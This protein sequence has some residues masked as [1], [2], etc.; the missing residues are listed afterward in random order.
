MTYKINFVSVFCFL[1]III[2]LISPS[3][4]VFGAKSGLMLWF[5]NIVPTLF[6]FLIIITLLN[7]LNGFLILEKPL[8]VLARLLHIP[9]YYTFAIITGFLCGYPMGALLSTNYYKENILSKNECE[10]LCICSNFISPMFLSGYALSMQ[11][12][13]SKKV[14]LL[15]SIY[16]P[17]IALFP[18]HKKVCKIN[19]KT[20]LPNN[21]N[22]KDIVNTKKNLISLLDTS[23]M[24]STS[25]ILKIGGYMILCSIISEYILTIPFKTDIIKAILLCI[26]EITRGIYYT[27]SLSSINMD[28]KNTILVFAICFG[29]VCI[30]LQSI[31]FLKSCDIPCGRY[32]LSKICQGILA[33]GVY[34]ILTYIFRF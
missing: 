33:A 3:I 31:S 7:L 20:T 30:I 28:I 18:I 25:T 1:A 26:I 22:T 27:F 6:P 23:I 12:S 9:S 15:I 4:A 32:V 13:F 5:N 21:T 29:G 16:L 17:I 11:S 8:S 2:V 34:I 24:T 19:S 14:T 10:F